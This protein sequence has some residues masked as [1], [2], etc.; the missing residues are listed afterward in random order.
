LR[1]R[2]LAAC[3]LGP[4]ARLLVSIGRHHPEKRLPM[5]IE[6]VGLANSSFRQPI[7]LY[8]V[9]DGL[10]R[11]SVERA[12]ARVPQAHVAGQVGDR[13]EVA[14]IMASADALI[15]GSGCE[16]FGLAVAE[17]LCCGAPL[18]VPSAGGARDLAAPAYAEIYPL[19][20]APGAATAIKRLL[21]RDRE[22]LSKAALL[23]AESRIGTADAHF[24]RLF[25]LYETLVRQRKPA[26][27]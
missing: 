9:G 23:A 7:G 10:A 15:H 27:T 16:T 20:E 14:R 26:G 4:E 21:S 11:A 19:G 22:T 18:I 5:L 13:A 24:D 12:A 6:A 8:L 17:A 3:G 2:M 25:A 1:A